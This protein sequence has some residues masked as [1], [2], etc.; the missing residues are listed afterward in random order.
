MFLRILLLLSYSCRVGH[1]VV[2]LRHERPT[3]PQREHVMTEKEGWFAFA[4]SSRRERRGGDAFSLFVV[5]ENYFY[6]SRTMEQKLPSSI[7]MK[8]VAAM[9][10][11]AKVRSLGIQ[12]S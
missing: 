2:K 11:L 5:S 3:Q 1:V 9:S 7:A 10:L 12:P 6:E 4:P 8:R